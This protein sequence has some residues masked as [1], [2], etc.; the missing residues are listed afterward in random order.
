MKVSVVGAGK[1]GLP[2]ACRFAQRGA[3]TFACDVN[4][5]LVDTINSGRSPIDEPGVDAIVRDTAADGRLRATTDTGGAVAQSDVV[6]IIV[7]ALLT[8]DHHADLSI[9]ESVTRI[10][11][12]SLRDE[13]LVIYETT[14]PVGTTRKLFAPLLA[15]SGRKFDLAFSPERVKSKHVLER[16]GITPKVVGG[17]TS[18]AGDRAEAFYREYLDAPVIR[19]PSLEAAELVKLAGMLYRDVTIALSN[20]I[21]RY[22]ERTGVDYPGIIEATNTDGE[23]AL[24]DPGIGVGGHCTPIYPYFLIHHAVEQG[25]H[26][27]LAEEARRI[28]DGQAEHA[29]ARLEKAIGSLRGRQVMILGLGFRPGVKEHL[30]S[31]AF[32]LRDV[33]AARGAKTTLADPLYTADEI[34]KH[35]FEPAT[36]DANGPAPEAVVLNTVH[37]EFRSPDFAGLRRRG[38]RAV[39][40]GR[41]AWSAEAIVSAGLVY[42]GIGRPAPAAV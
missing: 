30:C 26:V 40:D 23:A 41:N 8:P 12:G 31:P 28:N 21:A 27:T 1:M 20:Q 34:R 25:M 29:I 38:L 2:I 13:A 24:L 4:Q 16:L 6:V 18:E 37:P 15:A 32:L 10:A 22:A 42:V 7:P 5:K 3:Q 19:V 35:G 39:L 33:L 14:V 17:L 11:A 9:L 36:L